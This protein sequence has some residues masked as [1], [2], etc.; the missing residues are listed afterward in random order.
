MWRRP[1]RA[2][3]PQTATANADFTGRMVQA[4]M[5]SMIADNSA[6]SGSGTGSYSPVS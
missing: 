6:F 3:A 4:Q 2:V 1:M 5:D